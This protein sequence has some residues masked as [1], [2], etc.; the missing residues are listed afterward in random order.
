MLKCRKFPPTTSNHL[1]EHA[2]G[3][4]QV[5]RELRDVNGFD[6]GVGQ[7][8]EVLHHTPRVSQHY[9]AEAKQRRHCDAAFTCV[10]GGSMHG[11]P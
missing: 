4:G 1:R 10:E 5:A 9:W 6:V 2:G 8:V 3:D 7:L 11:D